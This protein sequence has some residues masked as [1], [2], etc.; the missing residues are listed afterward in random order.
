MTT[1]FRTSFTFPYA[2]ERTRAGAVAFRPQALIYIQAA[3]GAWHP[4]RLYADAGADLTLLR[5]D[6]CQLLGYRLR[7]GEP[8]WM[9]GIG[10]GLVRAY[11]QRI[12]IRLGTVEF[13]CQMAFS[14]RPSAALFR[15]Q[16]CPDAF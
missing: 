3:D 8:L 10:R 13:E 1:P 7:T 6:D 14:A 15:S 16:R 5:A 2:E 12:P 4:F 9:G 11:L